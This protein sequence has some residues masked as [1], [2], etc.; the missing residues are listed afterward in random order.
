MEQWMDPDP[1]TERESYTGDEVLDL[2]N[3]WFSLYA[4]HDHPSR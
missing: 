2:E 3:F 1:L 4:M